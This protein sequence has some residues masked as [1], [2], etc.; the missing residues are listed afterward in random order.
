MKFKPVKVPELG[1]YYYIQGSYWDNDD[2]LLTYLGEYIGRTK[3]INNHNFS[4]RHNGA[5]L[6]IQ[7]SIDD[8][9]L[10]ECSKLEWLV[11]Q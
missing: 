4:G 1:K 2:D 10:R 5:S 9:L 7:W 8:G 11:N 3:I 6:Y